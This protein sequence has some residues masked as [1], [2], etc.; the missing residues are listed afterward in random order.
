MMGAG[1]ESLVTVFSIVVS[2]SFFP[3]MII[4]AS[5]FVYEAHMIISNEFPS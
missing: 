1:K 5:S 3:G 4:Y 2:T